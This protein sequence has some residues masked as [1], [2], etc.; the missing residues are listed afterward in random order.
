MIDEKV[1]S[2]KEKVTTD[3]TTESDVVTEVKA[4]EMGG[5]ITGSTAGDVHP[6]ESQPVTDWDLAEKHGEV[7]GAPADKAPTDVAPVEKAPASEAPDALSSAP[8]AFKKTNG[9]SAKTLV[10]KDTSHGNLATNTTV[11]LDVTTCLGDQSKAADIDADPVTGAKP[12]ASSP[13]KSVKSEDL[14]SDMIRGDAHALKSASPEGTTQQSKDKLDLP[15]P[16]N[17]GRSSI[18]GP[19]KHVNGEGNANPSKNL[20]T[21]SHPRDEVNSNYSIGTP[22]GQPRPLLPHEW[23]KPI[24]L[25][26][27]QRMTTPDVSDRVTNSAGA[28]KRPDVPYKI[29]DDP[30][31]VASWGAKTLQKSEN[32]GGSDSQKTPTPSESASQIEPP[33]NPEYTSDIYANIRNRAVQP[34]EGAW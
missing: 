5:I 1:L 13:V 26:E 23:R 15:Q 12:E 2:E 31:S 4:T 29:K 9:E 24:P 32:S 34:R 20:L 19:V 3:K 16:G 33:R 7:D 8:A 14:K 27:L 28:H 17:A 22:E 11:H 25:G 18:F 21:C 30:L 6:L 10:P